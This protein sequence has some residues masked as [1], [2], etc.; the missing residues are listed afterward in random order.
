MLE[1]LPI[2]SENIEM[3]AEGKNATIEYEGREII[4]VPPHPSN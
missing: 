2:N 1:V 4:L 3:L